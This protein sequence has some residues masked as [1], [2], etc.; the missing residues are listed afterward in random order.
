VAR[1]RV[2]NDAGGFA[3]L[4]T[5]LAEAGYGYI[6]EYPIARMYA[7]ARVQKIN[8]GTNEILKELIARGL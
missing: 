1:R 4:L 8:G 2:D 7:D 5:L 6:T 3:A